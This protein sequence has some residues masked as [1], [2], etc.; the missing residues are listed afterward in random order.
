MQ[1]LTDKRNARVNDY[2]HK[3]TAQVIKTCLTHKISFVVVGDVAKSLDHINLGKK[4]NQ[5]F[6]NLSLGQFVDKLRYKL[7]Q[8]GITLKVANESYTSK[9]SFKDS[10]KM[11]KK[12]D[13]KA[14]PTY[15]GKRLKRGLYRSKDG[16]LINADVNGAY[17]I[18][19]KSDSTFSFQKLVNQVGNGIKSWLHPTARVFIK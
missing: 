4:T 19:R 17:N 2:L 8:H 7:G 15:S 3:A 11:P 16:T 18:L 1:S 6:V 14:K 10:D 12:Y 5:N 13:E 9:A